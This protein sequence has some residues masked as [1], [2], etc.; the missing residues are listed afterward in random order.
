MDRLV[1]SQQ[2][3]LPATADAMAT[4]GRTL[5]QDRNADR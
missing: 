1:T 4:P 3:R 2:R 5:A